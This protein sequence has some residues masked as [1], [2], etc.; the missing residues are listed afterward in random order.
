V[1]AVQEL[2]T[3][4]MQARVLG[5]LEAIGAA[6]PAAG[7]FA[8]GAIATLASPRS[9][10]LFAGI[11]VLVTLAGAAY[12]LRGSDWPTRGT[13]AAEEPAAALGHGPAPS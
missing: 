7:F 13:V 5:V 8:G 11:G 3:S 1:N 6:L 10:Y 2:T 12:A 9:A 4:A